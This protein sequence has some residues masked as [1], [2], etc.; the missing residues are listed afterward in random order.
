MFNS[1]LKSELNSLQ[2]E[3]VILER[4]VDALN[5]VMGVIEFDTDGHILTANENFL[6]VVGYGLNEIVG[7]HHRMFLHEIDAASANYQNFWRM[8]KAGNNNSDRFKRKSKSGKTIWLEASYNPIFNAEG[9]VEKIVKFAT[10]ITEKVQG[11]LD[12]RA[13]LTAINKVMAVIEFDVTGKILNANQNFLKTM[14]YTLDEIVGAHHKK[15]VRADYVQSSEYRVFWEKL[16]KGTPV[17]GT[18]RRIDKQGNEVWLEASYNPIFDIDGNVVRI[19]KYASDI[20]NNPNTKMLDQVIHDATEVIDRMASGDLSAQMRSHKSDT[21]SL[22][23]NN[24]EMLSKSLQSM[25]QKLSHV[26]SKV[27]TSAQNFLQQSNIIASGSESLDQQVQFSSSQLEN[28]FSTLKTATTM[29]RSGSHEARN[30][31]TTTKEVQSR[32]SQGVQVMS[33]TVAAMASI[34]ESSNKITEIVT[35]IDSIAFQTNLLA[36]NAAVEAARA[37]E[38]GRGFAVVAGEVRALAQK[39][40]DAAKEIRTL[41]DET[42]QRVDQGS[43]LAHASGEMLNEISKLI[44]SVG[45][46]IESISESANS[47]AIETEKAY[48]GVS[49]V[50]NVMQQNLSLV[51]ENTQSANEISY[52]ARDLAEDVN[53]FTFSKN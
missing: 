5:K 39:S 37:G 33:E 47:Q 10:D 25:G 35:L 21:P 17:A 42:T 23:D 28:A 52:Q 22:Y 34:Q 26:I 2:Q 19:I 50:Q 15:F 49:D 29:I 36:L 32:T 4:T 30:T 3:K 48:Q 13:Q 45:E 40:A 9:K 27:S 41:I 16:G 14:H 31:A 43:K 38:H 12:V 53:Y 1:H 24:I 11:E 6:N 18:F 51:A 20:G 7:K 8:L 44:D 46:K